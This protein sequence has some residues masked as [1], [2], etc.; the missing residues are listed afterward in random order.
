MIK[1][2]GRYDNARKMIYFEPSNN[3]LMVPEV[4]VEITELVAPGIKPY[5]MI[6]N[7]G[8]IW[9]KYEEK[10]LS[11]NLD[12]KGYSYK[13]LA[14]IDGAKNF[15][16]HR[17]VLASFNYIN[18][19][20]NLYVNHI[21]G[22]K[23]DNYIGNLEWVT[24]QENSIHAINTGLLNYNYKVT[25]EQ[26]HQICRLLVA[27]EIQTKIAEQC[28]VT[29][30]TVSA[31]ANKRSHCKISDLYDISK[32]KIAYHFTEEQVHKICKYYQDNAPYQPIEHYYADA[33]RYAGVKPETLKIRAAQKI[34]TK[35]SYR[36]ISKEYNF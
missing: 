24:A 19:C 25:D 29:V 9:H 18:G 32:R 10:I 12:S 26:V 3:I 13:P 23:S 6:S 8:R 33:V 34:Y 17:L 21:N 27:G 7:Y 20:E 36:H 35:D 2:N 11:I 30:Q 22:I 14:T 15:R 31:I 1:G 4:F 16:V 28:N 5:Y